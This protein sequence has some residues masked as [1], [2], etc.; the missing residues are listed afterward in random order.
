VAVVE[1]ISISIPGDEQEPVDLSV[2]EE[3]CPDHLMT[4]QK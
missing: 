3:M 2:R 1:R 4:D